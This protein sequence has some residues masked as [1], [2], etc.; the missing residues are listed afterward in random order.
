MTQW[1]KIGKGTGQFAEEINIEANKHEGLL[2][3]AIIRKM[4]II[5]NS[6]TQFHTH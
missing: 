3:I 2:N 1:E 5:S 4:Q 6:K